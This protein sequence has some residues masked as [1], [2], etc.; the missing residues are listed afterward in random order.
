MSARQEIIATLLR[1]KRPDLANC[2]AW[3]SVVLSADEETFKIKLSPK[4][5]DEFGFTLDSLAS[6]GGAQ[7][8]MAESLHRRLA[9]T[10]TVT[11]DELA[12][13]VWDADNTLDMAR[14]QM[15]FG[16]AR[17]AQGK[18]RAFKVFIKKYLPLVKGHRDV[19][20]VR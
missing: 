3:S 4:V 1:A 6:S 10:M 9:G 11:K 12:Y 18:A 13:L 16:G 17:D 20:F 14:D 5:R 2:V 15:G 7:A 8:K 19:R